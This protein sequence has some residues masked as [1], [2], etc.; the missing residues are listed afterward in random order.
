MLPFAMHTMVK[1]RCPH[2]GRD[3]VKLRSAVAVGM[4]HKCA[5]CKRTYRVSVLLSVN[6]KSSRAR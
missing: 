1:L 4:Q 5:H 6:A 3:E 2:C